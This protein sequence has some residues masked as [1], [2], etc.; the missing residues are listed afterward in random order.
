MEAAQ[1]VAQEMTS[2]RRAAVLPC[3]LFCD[4]PYESSIH[5]TPHPHIHDLRAS[6]ADAAAPE[7]ES[8]KPREEV[9]IACHRQLLPCAGNPFTSRHP[10]RAADVQRAYDEMLRLTIFLVLSSTQTSDDSTRGGPYRQPPRHSPWEASGAE[11]RLWHS[12]GKQLPID[13]GHHVARRALPSIAAAHGVD[14]NRA[15][16]AVFLL[17]QLAW[18]IVAGGAQLRAG[19]RLRLGYVVN[20]HDTSDEGA[21]A[22]SGARAPPPRAVQAVDSGRRHAASLAG[23]IWWLASGGGVA[24]GRLPPLTA[25]DWPFSDIRD[26][27]PAEVGRELASFAWPIESE[28]ELHRL[29]SLPNAAPVAVMGGEFTA[30]CR[31]RYTARYRRV[32]IS[33]DKRHSLVPGLH[34]RLDLRL[35]LM[36]CVW[37]DA[38]LFPPCTHQVLS[39]T[40][41][42]EAKRLDGRT[43][44]GVAFFI[45]CW[46]ARARRLLVEQPATLIPDLYLE[47]TQSIRPCDVAVG[48]G[49][50]H[51]EDNKP[52]YLF[53]RGRSAVGGRRL[54]ATQCSVGAT[55]DDGARLAR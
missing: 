47:P 13:P 27:W 9:F 10:R 6:D 19:R 36:L 53:E 51:D 30:A 43:F 52:V 16:A 14:L 5:V 18:L 39:D 32:A 15:H 26:A 12:G 21:P 42:R 8:D 11:P 35:V 22:W 20:E 23:A 3:H 48:A 1:Q 33:V 29:M 7:R 2:S 50:A 4:L 31:R 40:N 41:S 44:W 54:E 17:G 37:H 24:I 34:V 45:Y 28:T 49:G 55:L 38:F 46:C 25:G